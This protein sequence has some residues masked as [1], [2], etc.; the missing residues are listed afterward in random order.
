LEANVV[1]ELMFAVLDTD[2]PSGEEKKRSDPCCQNLSSILCYREQRVKEMKRCQE[3][4]EERRKGSVEQ[5][6]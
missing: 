5:K 1:D 6:Y 2:G 3:S 4:K